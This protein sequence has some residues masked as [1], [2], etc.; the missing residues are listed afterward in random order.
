MDVSGVEKGEEASW[1]SHLRDESAQEC[2][3]GPV[4][5]PQE[6]ALPGQD[7]LHA[8]IDTLPEGP[9]PSRMIEG[10]FLLGPALCR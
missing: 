1:H 5:F 7:F 8:S 4:P 9:L 2:G 10:E 6:G 3:K